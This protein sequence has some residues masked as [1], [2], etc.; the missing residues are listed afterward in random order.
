MFVLRDVQQLLD[1]GVVAI[2]SLPVFLVSLQ[3]SGAE[4][5]L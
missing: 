4:E 3:P 5:T 1:A 2:Y